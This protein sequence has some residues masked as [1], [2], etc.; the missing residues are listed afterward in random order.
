MKSTLA[1]F[2]A[3]IILFYS[4]ITSNAHSSSDNLNQQDQTEFG[5]HLAKHGLQC[6]SEKYL[7]NLIDNDLHSKHN[8]SQVSLFEVINGYSTFYHINYLHPKNPP[9][10]LKTDFRAQTVPCIERMGYSVNQYESWT[11]TGK[12]A[13]MYRVTKQNPADAKGP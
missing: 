12:W 11:S 6:E 5:Q 13:L 7:K 9:K 4:C 1:L 10:V 2:G 3:M 8:L